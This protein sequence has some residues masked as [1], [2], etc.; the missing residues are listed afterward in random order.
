M[1]ETDQS[2]HPIVVVAQLAT[3]A[4]LVQLGQQQRLKQ[5]EVTAA[6]EKKLESLATQLT[7][8]DM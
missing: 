1:A 7:I 8:P 3:S 4:N 2:K 5:C 6:E